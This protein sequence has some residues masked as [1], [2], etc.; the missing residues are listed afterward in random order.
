MLI[1]TGTGDRFFRT[2]ADI[3]ILE[4]VAPRYKYT[5]SGPGFKGQVQSFLKRVGDGT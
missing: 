1:L 5:C 3:A 2:G 4:S